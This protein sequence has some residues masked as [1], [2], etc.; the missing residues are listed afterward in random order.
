MASTSVGCP[1]EIE[2]IP[3]PRCD[4][5]FDANCEGETAIPFSRARYDKETGH[6]FNSP[7]EQVRYDESF[8]G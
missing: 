1:L 8:F 7:R 5:V 3:V 6:G 2:K 4:P